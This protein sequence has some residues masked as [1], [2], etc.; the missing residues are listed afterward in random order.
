MEAEG[1][2]CEATARL[3]DENN[4][5]NSCDDSMFSKSISTDKNSRKMRLMEEKNYL[6]DSEM[7]WSNNISVD[8]KYK[9]KMNTLNG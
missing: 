1:S 9:G 7:L 6:Y 3:F 2:D 5:K 4:C 8:S